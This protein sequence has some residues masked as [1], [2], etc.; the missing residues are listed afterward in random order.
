MK[1][2]RKSVNKYSLKNFYP[3]CWK[4]ADEKIIQFMYLDK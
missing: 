1:P 3:P 4:K 2:K